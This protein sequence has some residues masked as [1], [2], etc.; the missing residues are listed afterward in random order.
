MNVQCTADLTDH[1]GHKVKEVKARWKIG[2]D[3]EE[4]GQQ[5]DGCVLRGGKHQKCKFLERCKQVVQ[6]AKKPNGMRISSI[7]RHCIIISPK[8]EID[9]R[10]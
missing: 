8:C 5:Q 9:G 3:C 7:T 2:E 1:A 6:K 10:L 4:Q